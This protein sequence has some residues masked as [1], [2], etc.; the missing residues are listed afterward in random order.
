[1][2]PIN[3]SPIFNWCYELY[4]VHIYLRVE[5]EIRIEIEDFQKYEKK[6]NQWEMC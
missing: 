4:F 6:L 2:Y 1:M 5:L 3:F